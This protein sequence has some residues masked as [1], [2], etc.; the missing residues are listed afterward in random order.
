MQG[1]RASKRRRLLTNTTAYRRHATRRRRCFCVWWAQSSCSAT[2][3]GKSRV[4]CLG[5][6]RQEGQDVGRDVWK[7]PMSSSSSSIP[8][9]APGPARS[10]PA[11]GTG[12]TRRFIV[13]GAGEPGPAG[14]EVLGAAAAEVGGLGRGQHSADRA[15]LG[16]QPRDP[17]RHRRG[18]PIRRGRRRVPEAKVLLCCGLLSLVSRIASDCARDVDCVEGKVVV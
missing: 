17:V 12:R 9:P 2:L 15:P 11:Q 8:L 5:E 16:H 6:R 7:G 1:R 10:R 4:Q 13:D 3:H 18:E 14:V